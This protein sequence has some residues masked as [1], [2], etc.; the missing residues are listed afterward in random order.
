MN[1]KIIAIES[2]K[3]QAKRLS[4]KYPSLKNEL[5]ELESHL[6]ENFKLGKP[7]GQNCYKIRI[8]IKSKGSGKSGGARVI[9]NIA[10]LDKTIFLLSIYDKSETENISDS[11]LKIL[12]QHIHKS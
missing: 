9:T 2:F 12:L 10:V 3:R 8:G 1:F 6:T 11:D 7:I 4:K 5:A